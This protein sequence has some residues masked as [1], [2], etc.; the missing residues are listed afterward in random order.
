M[1]AIEGGGYVKTP[2][3]KSAKNHPQKYFQKNVNGVLTYP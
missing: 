1:A 2:V 3:P